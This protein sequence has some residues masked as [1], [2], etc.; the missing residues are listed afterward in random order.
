VRVTVLKIHKKYNV[1]SV[2]HDVNW[3]DV[4]CCVLLQETKHKSMHT[5]VTTIIFQ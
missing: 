5:D 3:A 1:C 4:G 2:S